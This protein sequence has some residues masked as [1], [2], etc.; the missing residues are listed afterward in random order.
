[1]A[2]V[3]ILKWGSEEQKKQWLPRLAS[4]TLAS[5]CLSEWGSGSDAFA[6][7]TTATDKGSH[8]VL[9]GSKA[10]ITNA[11]E[12]GLFVVF[13]TTDPKLGYKGISA[14]VV[15]DRSAPGL[16]VQKSE[17]KLGI[18]ASSTCEVTLTDVAVDKKNVL[19]PLGKG[20]KIAIESL[21]EGR[22]G[23]GAQ[24]LGVAQGAFDVM[25]P[26]VLERKQFG[27]PIANFQGMQFG[28]SRC[29]VQIEAA[30]LMVYNA[31]RLKESGL[32]FVREAAMAKLYA[33]EVAENVASF[34]VEAMGGMGF[35]K[36]SGVEKFYRDAK[37]GKIYEGTSS[38]QL[39]TIAKD[40]YRAATLN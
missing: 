14:F 2:N 3:G 12:A 9:N 1:M 34:A 33:S 31:A 5:F 23:I 16:T 21:N 8:Y 10:W 22:I 13:A 4:N 32:P 35:I 24:M 28:V 30:R 18:R 36:D 27:S 39:Q 6:L 17:D 38:I 29:A 15:D 40:I 19:G 11:R 20:Y 25:L 26:Y 37:I 7:K